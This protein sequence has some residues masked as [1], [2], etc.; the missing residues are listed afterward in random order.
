MCGGS[1]EVEAGATVIECEY[2]G[3]QQTLP[4][5][6]DDRRANMYDRANHFR[7]NND[8]DKAMGIYENILNEDGTVNYKKVQIGRRMGTEYE[9]LSGLNDGDKVVTGGQIR[10]KD[11][12]KVIVNE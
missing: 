2:C 5:L 7:R 1:L 6:D 8:F 12:I 11:G 3:T 4:K 10:L 9:I